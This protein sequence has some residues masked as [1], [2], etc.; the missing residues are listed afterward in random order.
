[1][2][3]LPSQSDLLVQRPSATAFMFPDDASSDAV[4]ELDVQN[5]CFCVAATFC[6]NAP[7]LVAGTLRLA[8]SFLLCPFPGTV[9]IDVL[10]AACTSYIF[11]EYFKNEAPLSFVCGT[12]IF[13]HVSI[14]VTPNA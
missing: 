13:H 5:I 10:R 4:V 3:P 8:V 9:C 2:A 1:M 6:T 12:V 14:N 11:L 7:Y